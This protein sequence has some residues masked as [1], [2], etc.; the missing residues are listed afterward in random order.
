MAGAEVLYIGR[1]GVVNE[2]TLFIQSRALQTD[3]FSPFI[4][5]L[6]SGSILVACCWS[7]SE[8]ASFL[9][10]ALHESDL[11]RKSW[12]SLP[13]YSR[14]YFEKSINNHSWVTRI[15]YNTYH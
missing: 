3:Q 13:E 1:H 15:E 14:V 10:T 5:C 12:I 11:N 6:L 4:Q 9:T 7:Q 8:P 2:V